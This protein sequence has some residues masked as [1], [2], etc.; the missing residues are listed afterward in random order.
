ME[1]FPIL[2]VHISGYHVE[3]TF[4]SG[5]C[6]LNSATPTHF[7]QGAVLSRQS[8]GQE[9]SLNS[10]NW[11]QGGPVPVLRKLLK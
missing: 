3:S 10:D 9:N 2:E 11:T 4:V 5:F 8:H 1:H 6:D 7:T